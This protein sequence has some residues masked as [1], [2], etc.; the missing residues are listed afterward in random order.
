[1]DDPF[2]RPPLWEDITSSIQNI[3][4]ENAVMLG[5]TITQVKMETVDDPLLET[6]STPLLSPL[7]IKTEK[8][9]PQT[10]LTPNLNQQQHP[11]H[12]QPHQHANHQQHHQGPCTHHHNNGTLH[13]HNLGTLNNNNHHHPSHHH[14]HHTNNTGN[15]DNTSRSNSNN[16]TNN[17]N[18]D[19][20]TNNNNNQNS[21]NNN[22]SYL[23][24]GSNYPAAQ[25]QPSS[26][27][28][29]YL[30]PN[31]NGSGNLNLH[32]TNQS[33]MPPNCNSNNSNAGYAYNWQSHS[34]VNE[35]ICVIINRKEILNEIIKFYSFYLFTDHLSFKIFT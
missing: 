24:S 15:N 33:Q 21:N 22:N 5:S 35:Y 29:S 18:N 4:P 27:L 34:Q 10:H 17:N 19:S 26:N 7:E 8:T 16:N 11:N 3:D 12:Q 13:H 9:H 20:I 30:G 6:F 23:L 14:P 31:T 25:S 1:M 2:L 32:H 28:N